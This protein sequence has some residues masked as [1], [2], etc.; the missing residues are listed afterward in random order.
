MPSRDRSGA[1]GDVGPIYAIAPSFNAASTTRFQPGASNFPAIGAQQ[2][3]LIR[4]RSIPSRRID[5]GAPVCL[6]GAF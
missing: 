5:A 4:T 6:N 1:E 2:G 3:P